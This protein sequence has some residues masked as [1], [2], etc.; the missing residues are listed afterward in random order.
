MPIYSDIL[1]ELRKDKHITQEQMGKMFH[2]SQSSY[3]DYENG[4][5]EMGPLMLDCL[6]DILGTSTDYILGRT[7]VM[8]PYPRRSQ[9]TYKKQDSSPLARLRRAASLCTGKDIKNGPV[10]QRYGAVDLFCEDPLRPAWR[11]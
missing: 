4:V 9:P 1:K 6:A 3:C 10:P 2:M 5:R 8:E 7:D 11:R